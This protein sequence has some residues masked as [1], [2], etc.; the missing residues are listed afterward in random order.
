V[1]GTERGRIWQKL[2]V[3]P[4]SESLAD[5]RSAY[6]AQNVTAAA[7]RGGTHATTRPTHP[8]CRAR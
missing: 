8:R 3:D 2:R 5:H 6:I 4:G 7:H 1:Q